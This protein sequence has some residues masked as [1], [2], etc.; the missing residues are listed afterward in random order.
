MTQLPSNSPRYSPDLLRLALGIVFFHF[1]FLKFFPDL[2]SAE[3]LAT[4]TIIRLTGGRMDAA[5]ALWWLALLECVIGAGFLL[6]IGLRFISILFLLHMI[7]TFMPIF[8]LPELAFKFA[9]LAPTLEGQYILKNI[10]FVAAGWTVLLPHCWPDRAARP[11]PA[12][13][14]PTTP[15]APTVAGA[16]DPA[17]HAIA[18]LVTPDASAAK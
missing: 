8:V 11:V 13:P 14:V 9:P 7:G 3:M 16:G 6:N 1:G 18:T 10:V 15:A 12:R 2:S 4:Q 5:T 17:C